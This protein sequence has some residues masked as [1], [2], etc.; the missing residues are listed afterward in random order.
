MP[1]Y[2]LLIHEDEA[3][4]TA[5]IGEPEV[6]FLEGYRGRLGRADPLGPGLVEVRPRERGDDGRT[7]A[8]GITG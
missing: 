4:R 6:A 2:V 8:A 5:M 1:R 3:E 7:G